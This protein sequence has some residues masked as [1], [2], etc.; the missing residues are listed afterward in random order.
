MSKCV[1]QICTM[2]H[3]RWICALRIKRLLDDS[4][5]HMHI[6]YKHRDGMHVDV[7]IVNNKKDGAI[8]KHK[9]PILI[10]F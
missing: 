10:S 1:V 3:L 7:L 6:E 8:Q 2:C 5:Y 4:I 9:L